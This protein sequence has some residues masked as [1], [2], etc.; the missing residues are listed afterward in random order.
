M[1]ATVGVSRV[2]AQSSS[3]LVAEFQEAAGK[4]RVPK[5]LL[6]AIGFVNTRWEM[7]PPGTSDYEEGKLEGKGTYGVMALV[8]TPRLILWARRQGLPASRW[9]GS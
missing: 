7:P 9:S 6:L 2:L 1:L 4:Y 3:S 5:E 8:R